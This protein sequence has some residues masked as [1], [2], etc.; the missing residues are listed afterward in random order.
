V[1]HCS[2]LSYD[3]QLQGLTWLQE[4][5]SE[6]ISTNN[7]APADCNDLALPVTVSVRLDAVNLRW[8]PSGKAKATYLPVRLLTPAQAHAVRIGSLS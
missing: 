8:T 3:V 2:L 6:L 1:A 4:L 7:S 5:L